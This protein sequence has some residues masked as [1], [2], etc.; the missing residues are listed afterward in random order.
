V[1]PAVVLAAGM[2]SRMGRPKATLVLDSGQTFLERIV[3]TFQDAGADD[4]FVVVGHA[5]DTIA[6]EF[7]RS[8][9]AARFVLN[10]DYERGQLSSLL[11]GLGAVD[12]PGVRAALVTL[13]DAPLVSADTVRAVMDRYARTEAPIV[14]PVSRD[15]V[16]HGHPV[17]IDR[18]LFSALR[19]ADPATGAKPVVRAHVSPAGDV[20]TDDE[21]AFGDIDTPAEY[22][23][24][25]G[26]DDAV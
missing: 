18:S 3:R 17:L 13:V 14:R 23:A 10:R 25:V 19:G 2:S 1:I 22:R 4:V 8:G 16:R 6:D 20:V 12:R 11:V 5:A 21:G 26:S 9:L 7:A 24:V 15:G